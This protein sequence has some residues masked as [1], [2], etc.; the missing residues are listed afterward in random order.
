MILI[1]GCSFTAGVGLQEPKK[2]A[3]PALFRLMVN[4][5][6]VVDL[7]EGGKDNLEMYHQFMTWIAWA[8]RN[9]AVMPK[10]I[11]WQTTM[12]S[13]IGVRLFDRESEKYNDLQSQLSDYCERYIKL[14]CY[15]TYEKLYRRKIQARKQNDLKQLQEIKNMGMGDFLLS[16]DEYGNPYDIQPIGDRHK[17]PVGELKTCGLIFSLQ[18]ICEVLGIRLIILNY[19]GNPKAMKGDP[20][21]EAIDRDNYVFHNSRYYGL[22]DALTQHGFDQ[23]PCGHWNVDAQL[24]QADIVYDFWK[25]NNQTKISERLYN[26]VKEDTIYRYTV[27]DT[28][29]VTKQLLK[30]LNLGQKKQ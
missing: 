17:S 12:H 2:H 27:N 6:T 25:N 30:T 16:T 20:L 29:L 24:Y 18:T 22:H 7:S 10:T 15:G 19:S 3:W 13:R 4:S 26:R 28:T 14:D 8:K 5:E 11:I 21:F 23:F 1:N 9:K